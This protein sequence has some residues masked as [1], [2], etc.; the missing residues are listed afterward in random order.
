MSIPNA[1]IVGS[2]AIAASIIGARFIAPY[3]LASGTAVVWRVN[4]ITG[5]VELCNFQVN[6]DN[7]AVANPRCR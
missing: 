1:I 2:L 6:V 5:A 4:A 3:Q 7:P